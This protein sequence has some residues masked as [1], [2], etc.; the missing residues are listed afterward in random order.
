MFNR[1][2]KRG[3]IDGL[4]S[5]IKAITGN[6]D[7]NDAERYDQAI[8]T[9]SDNQIKMK[10]LLKE[11]ITI[12]QRSIQNFEQNTKKLAHNELI[13]K[14]RI[15]QIERF[16][17]DTQLEKIEVYN[18]FLLYSLLSQITTTFQV[19]YDAFERIEVAITFSK[20]N[21]FH[22]SIIE[23]KDLLLE[24]SSINKYLEKN[25]LPFEPVLENT[26]LF[27]KVIEI[28]S[29]SKG[30]QIIFILQ[31]PIVQLESY[32][33]YHLY[34]LPIPISDSFKTIIPHSKYLLLNEQTYSFSDVKCQKVM[35]EEYLCQENNI[36]KIENDIPC[37][38]KLLKY[39]RNVTNCQYTP[40][41]LSSTKIQKMEDNKWI[42]VTPQNVVAHQKC[43]NNQDNIPLN[44]SYVLELNNQCV[45]RIED[46][47]IKTLQNVKPNFKQI[48]LPKIQFSKS[49][50]KNDSY[51][52]KPLQLET[53][54][55]DEIKS[56]HSVL[57]EQQNK[58]NNITEVP[59]HFHRISF[60]T[61]LLYIILT[62]ISFYVMY[63]YVK[64]LR[65]SNIARRNEEAENRETPMEPTNS[66][67]TPIVLSRAGGVISRI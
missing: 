56:V 25:K 48:K 29:Y 9:L 37:E 18:Y 54:N 52:I 35:S 19:I 55:L 62:I 60:Y 23:P 49:F 33:Y 2:N 8:V 4:G 16:I 41:R 66:G 17:H 46:N 40:V 30:N 7:Q 11:Q 27:E 21:I 20:L 45:V 67:P 61:I 10:S 65:S 44:G 12:L 15:A 14:S 59:V 31:I 6:L 5:I 47:V 36:V 51:N 57:N 50:P 53:I 34:S 3:I 38:V 39:S 43:G 13:L 64:K 1:K 32:N 28:K 63:C 26:L 58:L 22:N 42:I 24:I